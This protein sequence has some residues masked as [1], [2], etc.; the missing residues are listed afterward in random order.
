M[1]IKDMKNSYF[2]ACTFATCLFGAS[3]TFVPQGPAPLN[4][5][6]V[7]SPSGLSMNQNGAI[8]TVAVNPGDAQ[9]LYIGAVSGG[10]WSSADFGTS[11]SPLLDHQ[12]DLSISS[13]TFDSTD[14]TH[15]T[16]V[17]GTGF[18]SSGFIGPNPSGLYRTTN[19]GSSWTSLG[20]ATLANMTISGI[21]AQGSTI[22]TSTF[23][24][25][26]AQPETGYGLFVSTDT[27]SSFALQPTG[28]AGQLGAGPVSSLAVDPE[29]PTTIYAA[30]SAVTFGNYQDT[31][32]YKSVNGGTSWVS[33]FGESE[34][35]GFIN[36]SANTAMKVATGPAGSIAVL[37]IE[38]FPSDQAVFLSLDSGNTWTQ[39]DINSI[40][41]EIQA[42]T[43]KSAVAIDPIN[44]NVVYISG[45]TTPTDLNGGFPGT[46][47]RL[48]YSAPNTDVHSLILGSDGSASHA[49][50]RK[51]LALSSGDLIVTSD[52][53]I[54]LRSNASSS[55]G[56]WSGLNGENLAT[57]EPYSV[58][59]D[60]NNQFIMAASQDNGICTQNGPGNP[61]YTQVF[62]GDGGLG[63]INDQSSDSQSVYY[64]TMQDEA[65]PYRML[66]NSGTFSTFNTIFFTPL[67]TTPVTPITLNRNNP[68]WLAVVSQNSPSGLLISIAQDLPPFSDELNQTTAGTCP[69][70]V[71]GI[72]YGTEDQL[73]ALVLCSD[74]SGL[75]FT[76]NA[77]T[78]PI[79]LLSAYAT[80]SGNTSPTAVVFDTRTYQHI[81][82]TDAT[83]IYKTVNAGTS[84]TGPLVI[85]SNLSLINTLEFIS[86]NGVN[87]LLAGG[88]SSNPSLGTVAVADCDPSGNL[89]DWRLFGLDLPNAYVE[90]LD[91]NTKTD[92]LLAGL[93][94]RG[95]W[96][97]YDVTS[98]FASA[99]VLQFGLANNDSTP[100][101]SILNGSRSLEKYGTGTLTISDN[102][103]F[104]GLATVHAGKMIING[105]I[106]GGVTV[107][108]GATL[109]GVGSIG[110]AVTIESG[111]T[112]SPGNS[113]GTITLGS[114]ALA[115]GATTVIEVS[116]SDA[117]QIIVA[118]VANLNGEL[119]VIQESGS[120]ITP[121]QYTILNAESI[122]GTFSSASLSSTTSGLSLSVNYFPTSVQ[123]VINSH[124]ST[125][126]L[127][128]NDALFANYL[129]T[130]AMDSTASQLLAHLPKASLSRAVNV[131]SPA[132]N[133][134]S[135]FVVAKTALLTE[136]TMRTRNVNS[137]FT[138]L[139]EALFAQHDFPQDSPWA[140]RAMLAFFSTKAKDKIPAGSLVEEVRTDEKN[141]LWASGFADFAH[142]DEQ[143]QIPSL[144]FRVA[145]VVLGYNRF[146]D[147]GWVGAAASYANISIS[148]NN[149]MG[150]GNINNFTFTPYGTIYFDHAYLELS[151]TGAY[152][153][154]KQKRHIAFTGF[155]QTAKSSFQSWQLTP[156]MGF[157]YDYAWSSFVLEPF[158]GFDLVTTWQPGFQEKGS[159]TFNMRQ[160]KQTSF[161][162][163]SEIGL[164]FYQ[165]WEGSWGVC[166]LRE[167]GAYVNQEPFGV[168]A[169]N[170][171]LV[172][173]NTTFTSSSFNQNQN[174][175][176]F[177]FSGIV[178]A[179]NG[180]F[181]SFAL[182][183]DVGSSYI[184]FQPQID[185][186]WLF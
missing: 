68:T 67:L 155:N 123:I 92:V 51:I 120:Y 36:P 79:A 72:S 14:L 95:A 38:E 161:F 66:C 125:E 145:G 82:V 154:T 130:D 23:E 141:E 183:G 65:Y 117:S 70:S 100:D 173:N 44:P 54:A 111:A 41:S 135:N 149:N 32:L 134:I 160:K 137:Q 93:W 113:I 3:Q 2:L 64:F 57:L 153:P 178:K 143:N 162:L 18:T 74:T 94:G 133:A 115:S 20:S 9:N 58:A 39:L 29:T 182:D 98:N 80:Q 55:G 45:S 168:G 127:H 112:L 86:S 13:L 6:I 15:Q 77:Q 169:V 104:N 108:S 8:Q 21:I 75:Y 152:N 148:Q 177:G 171:G 109:K 7:T 78:T 19:G 50:T 99:T 85:P 84:F 158:I 172:G 146:F 71:I 31:A 87:A 144:F 96:T 147:T 132:R 110:G 33:I 181:A 56:S 118:G 63:F 180:F 16:L 175:F 139:S 47:Y 24:P 101:A 151:M 156:H 165:Q 40:S 4:G 167:T 61:V 76:D 89:T 174:L 62:P 59:Y 124:I 179:T 170:A 186:G 163:Q 37:A 12:L 22:F 136:K 52:G 27:G 103:T 185:F 114:L 150:S 126:N 43:N 105:S 90:T 46:V 5:E 140:G 102:P 28:G 26:R 30:V 106:S 97:M 138:H 128:G 122:T 121:L 119:S 60:G 10:V 11:W 157:G 53:G 83:Y 166:T 49:D 159:P 81:F 25:T 131:S 73:H 116:P 17:A 48:T 35:G 107:N 91:Y 176:F 34:S 88:Y 184:S 142:Q 129:N 69:D 1:Y 164:R 42:N